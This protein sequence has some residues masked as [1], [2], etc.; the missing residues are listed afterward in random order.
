MTTTTTTGQ[1]GDHKETQETTEPPSSDEIQE[2][3]RNAALKYWRIQEHTRQHSGVQHGASA[4]H[5]FPSHSEHGYPPTAIP[6]AIRCSCKEWMWVQ[7]MHWSDVTRP[8]ERFVTLR[9]LAAPPP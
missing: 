8:R 2:H 4:S 3:F 1:S 9:V 5:I 6:T 7:S